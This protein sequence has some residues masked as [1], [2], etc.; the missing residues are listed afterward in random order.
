MMMHR[1]LTA[2]QSNFWAEIAAIDSDLGN[3]V[4][5]LLHEGESVESIK[6]RLRRCMA[7]STNA[8]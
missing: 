6:E 7:L 2:D 5:D 1:H 8:A 3:K 4:L